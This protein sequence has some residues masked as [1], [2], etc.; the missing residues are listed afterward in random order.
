MIEKV[1]LHIDTIGYSSKKE[2]KDKDKHID[3]A[4]EIKCRVQN[5]KPVE[6]TIPEL[7]NIIEN[8][9]SVSPTIMKGLKA[10]DF[11]EQQVFM[12]DIDNTYE[13]YPILSVEEAINICKNNNIPL[14]FYYYSFSHTEEKPKYRLV[15]ILDKAVTNKEIRDKINKNLVS[16]FPQADKSCV[17]ADRIYYGTNKE[18]KICNIDETLSVEHI[19]SLSPPLEEKQT[20]KQEYDTELDKL[21]AEFDFFSYL[22]KRNGPIYR[23]GSNY[24]TFENCEICGH[25][26]DLTY[27]QDTNTFKCFGA[28]GGQAGTIIDY[29]MITEKLTLR[30]AI[31]KFKYELCEIEK[32]NNSI[33]TIS[34][35]ELLSMN[36]EKPYIVVENM[37]YQ[38]FT[39][40]G[41][42]PKIRKK[43][44]MS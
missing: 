25:K 13:Q 29:L 30:Q 35:K 23:Q 15:F 41:G 22:E 19:L 20:Q 42:P 24:I 32:P 8:G 40:L 1:K 27:Y 28:N 3:K 14:A 43:L 34:A 37:L 12:V 18:A 6:L 44:V 7:I 26:E 17:N 33:Q 4:N 38:G 16:L 21:K 31:D 10:N 5:S 11:V 36:L 39:I 9:K 2:I